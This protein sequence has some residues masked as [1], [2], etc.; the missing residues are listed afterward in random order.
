MLGNDEKPTPAGHSDQTL[1]RGETSDGEGGGG[2]E[3][4]R[5]SR[6]FG[7]CTRYPAGDGGKQRTARVRSNFVTVDKN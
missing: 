6:T 7:F 5:M 4:K 1:I 2:S 3:I